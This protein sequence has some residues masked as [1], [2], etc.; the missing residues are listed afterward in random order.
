[1]GRPMMAA[2]LFVHWGHTVIALVWPTA[3]LP[4]TWAHSLSVANVPKREENAA[5]KMCNITRL[6]AAFLSPH[7]PCPLS[8]HLNRCFPSSWD[9]GSFPCRPQ[10]KCYFLEEGFTATLLPHHA[11]MSL[12]C[13]LKV[14]Q[15]LHQSPHRRAQRLCW[16]CQFPG[17]GI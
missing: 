6:L 5:P 15:S 4:T 8:E 13:P 2:T 7:T 3:H 17:P 10:C 11:S 16:S 9:T 14:P 12:L 1:M